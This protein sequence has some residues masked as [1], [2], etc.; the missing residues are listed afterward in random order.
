MTV[1]AARSEL[2]K[3]DRRSRPT[4]EL[5]KSSTPLVTRGACPGLA[6]AGLVPAAA[7]YADKLVSLVRKRRLTA[8]S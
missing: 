2:M 5:A 7:T 3:S 8:V 6:L 1:S 4:G